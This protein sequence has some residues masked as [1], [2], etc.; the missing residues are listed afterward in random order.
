MHA[1][2]KFRIGAECRRLIDGF[3]RAHKPI[4]AGLIRAAGLTGGDR[5]TKV[6]GQAS[7][8]EHRG[9]Q[10]QPLEHLAHISPAVVCVLNVGQDLPPCEIGFRGCAYGRIIK[11]RGIAFDLAQTLCGCDFRKRRHFSARPARSA[12]FRHR[13]SSDFSLARR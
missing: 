7:M 8:G 12:T 1:G 4:L 11:W 10:A 5:G 6:A 9:V 3:R 2:E 13:A